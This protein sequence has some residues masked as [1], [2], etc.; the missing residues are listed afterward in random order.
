MHNVS[1]EEI[2]N[3]ESYNSSNAEA[4]AF[5]FNESNKNGDIDDL[6]VGFSC[7]DGNCQCTLHSKGTLVQ[8]WVDGE[9]N[10]CC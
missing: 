4:A 6:F 1:Y 5:L 9:E 10:D 7:I 2:D 8:K 3:I